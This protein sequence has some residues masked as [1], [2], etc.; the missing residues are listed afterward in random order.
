MIGRTNTKKL[1]NRCKGPE[2][3]K[4]AGFNYPG[5][6]PLLYCSDHKLDGMVNMNGTM[7]VTCQASSV[8]RQGVFGII[9]ERK[10]YCGDHKS[11]DMTNVKAKRCTKCKTRQCHY[12]ERTGN[13]PTMCG[14][15]APREWICVTHA[16]CHC[17][18]VEPTFGREEHKPTHCKDCREP[19]MWDVKNAKCT[20]CQV[21]IHRFGPPGGP[22][23]HCFECKTSDM[24]NLV[25]RRCAECKTLASFGEEKLA[26]HCF[27]H[28]S[29]TMREVKTRR[30][31]QCG[32]HRAYY[33]I[34]DNTHCRFCRTPEM[35]DYVNT[36]CPCGVFVT[37]NKYRGLC[38]GCFVDRFP[39][40]PIT[41]HYRVKE[42]AAVNKVCD[43]EFDRDHPN[44]KNKTV[45]GG[46]SGRRPDILVIKSTHAVIVE[47]DEYQ[48]LA[49]MD[50]DIRIR[51]LQA[52]L[53]GKPLH[54][55][56]F[57]PDG[58][59]IRGGIISS[60]WRDGRIKKGREKE[61]EERILQLAALVDGCCLDPPGERLV[62][63]KLY[64]DTIG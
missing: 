40:E 32:F 46:R 39:D 3:K 62:V 18:R 56:R 48:H 51:E 55:V 59:R 60:P 25:S 63:H 10:R 44:T 54:V 21:N 11:P 36:R 1:S 58:Y 34:G 61:W 45:V 4:Q 13:K 30:C 43:E 33:G 23:S 12:A 19:D 2:C 26:T 9:G 64:Y 27:T 8:Y 20:I 38:T 14:T 41:A 53:D 37:G 47:I 7:C 24:V 57:N 16:K 22:R 28:K 31:V 50:D 29:P 52:D 35:K 42:I 49:Y 15:C 5:V 17:G 6:K